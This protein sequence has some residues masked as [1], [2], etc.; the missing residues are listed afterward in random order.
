MSQLAQSVTPVLQGGGAR[1]V[2]I[3]GRVLLALLFILA[4]ALK[5]VGPAPFLAHMAEHRLP[6]F[7]LIGVIALELG[8]GLAV[9][10]GWKLP[11]AAGALAVFCVATALIFHSNFSDKAERTLFAKDLAICGGLLVLASTAIA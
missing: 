3:A 7:L 1:Y 8:A 4:G 5:I 6:G 11:Y 2:L 10:L 9:L